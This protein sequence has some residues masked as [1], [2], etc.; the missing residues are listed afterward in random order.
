MN[1]VEGMEFLLEKIGDTKTN[2]D[3]LRNMNT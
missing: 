3:F 1:I 2:R